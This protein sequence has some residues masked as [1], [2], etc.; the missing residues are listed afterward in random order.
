M[1]RAERSG[2]VRAIPHLLVAGYALI[3]LSWIFSIPPDTAPDERFHY[4]K[5]VAAGRGQIFLKD[6]P[7]AAGPPPATQDLRW[8]RI[9]TRLVRIPERYDPAAFDCY[10]GRLYPKQCPG[11]S[12]DSDKAKELGTYVGRYPPYSYVIPGYLSRLGASA[13]SALLLGRVGIGLVSLVF[14][15][16]AVYAAWDPG[17]AWSITGVMLAVTPMTAYGMATMSSSGP[18]TSAA[19]CFMACLLRVASERPVRRFIWPALTISA[20]ALALTR[21]LGF[22]WVAAGLAMVALWAGRSRVVQIVKESKRQSAMF[23][24]AV[25]SAAIAAVAWQLT[26]QTRPELAAGALARALRAAPPV[27]TALYM[28]VIGNFG[29]LDVPL[30]RIAYAAWTLALAALIFLALAGRGPARRRLTLLLAGAGIAV[31]AVGLEAVMRSIAFGAQGRHL[32]PL[33]VFL[34]L[35]AGETAHA[36]ERKQPVAGLLPGL[37]AF[38]SAGC[39]G[40]GWLAVAR[41]YTSRDG[42]PFAFLDGRYWA[43]PAGWGIWAVMA[44][45]GVALIVVAGGMLLRKALRPLK[46]PAQASPEA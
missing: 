10:E 36:Q 7:P 5:A 45:A 17:R 29:A 9:Q 25:V 26:Q 34:P 31:F 27:L 38:V 42:G 23:L 22:M 21:D 30:P 12:P 20:A 35:L 14:V 4:L 3:V 2:K 43:P 40:L 19:I 8:L 18:E 39:I 24:A 6:P 16:A 15:A 32:L 1:N 37:I 11:K 41:R 46:E 33:A 44:A 28:Q 13:E